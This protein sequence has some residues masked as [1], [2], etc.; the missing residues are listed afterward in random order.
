MAFDAK[1]FKV[2]VASPGDVTEER[3]AI[4]EV[5]ARWNNVN[6]EAINV[7]LLPVKWETHSAPLMGNRA[8]GV[9]NDQLVT[10]CDMA[11]G[12][13]WTRLG[14]PTGV[15]ESGTAEE[16]EWFIQHERPV[17]VYFSSRSIDPTK[18]DIDQYKALKEFEGKMQKIGLTGAYSNITDFKEQ[19][20]NQLSINVKLLT[21]GTPIARPSEAA[22][23]EKA[24]TLKKV[25]KGESVYME[26]Y[27]KDGQVR[28]FIVKGNTKGL[29]EGLKELKGRWNSP[30]GGWVF[31]KT[32]EVE[33]AEFLKKNA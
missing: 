27:E 22:A 12:V 16:I 15:S 9:I 29:K 23:R 6:S 17:M 19:L 1:V 2:L 25:L 20:F 13:F 5:I 24:A 7:V 26:D 11:I 10:T 33:V 28:S 32:K 21:S 31:P 30:L 4:P 3:E 14:S 18:L 8:Q